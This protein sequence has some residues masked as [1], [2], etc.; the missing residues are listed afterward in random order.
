MPVVPA[1]WEAQ[2]GELME[3]TNL[4]PAWVTWQ[5]PISLK[6]KKKRK[7]EGK[8][9][10][11]TAILG[12]KHCLWR[13]Y[14]NCYMITWEAFQILGHMWWLTPVILTLWE[15]AAGRSLEV[16]NLRAA[17]PTWWNP[18]STKITKFSQAWWWVPV[19]PATWEAEAKESLALK[20]WVL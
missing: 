15:D 19:I 5:N 17:W 18:V 16:V 2:V 3:S 13:Q 11:H 7:K 9:L 6:K 14:E 1:L 10:W 8:T 12:D 20:R 4:R